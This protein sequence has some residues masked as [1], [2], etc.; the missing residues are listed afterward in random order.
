MPLRLLGREAFNQHHLER[1]PP[2]MVVVHSNIKIQGCI[3]DVDGRAGTLDVEEF[4]IKF[5]GV[6]CTKYNQSARSNPYTII[7]NYTV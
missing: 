1:G 2:R 5:H 7:S 3:V 4:G 6:T